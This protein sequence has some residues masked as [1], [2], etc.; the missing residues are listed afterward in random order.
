MGELKLGREAPRIYPLIEAFRGRVWRNRAALYGREATLIS[1]L[2][3]LYGFLLDQ[4]L[5]WELGIIGSLLS[6]TWTGGSTLWVN[7]RRC[8]LIRHGSWGEAVITK[9][10][11][12][13]LWHEMFR[14]QE[15][16][17]YRL[18]YRY[19][20]EGQGLEGEITL[21][22]CAYDRLKV[23]EQLIIAYDPDRPARS[24]PLRVAVMKIPH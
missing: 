7:L 23:D 24:I 15:H 22:R 3:F 19:E 4:G 6:I 1:A 20:I 12:M 13:R 9:R 21:C 11:P 16:R 18:Q 2:I 14:A 8:A 10:V 5:M 17:S